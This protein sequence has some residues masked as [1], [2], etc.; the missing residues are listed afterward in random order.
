MKSEFLTVTSHEFGTPITILKG[1]ISMFL[2]GTFG[3]L[4]KLQRKRIESLK[5]SIDRLAKMRR[6]TILLSKLDS[7]KLRLKKEKIAINE[8]IENIANEISI[9]AKKNNQ[10]IKTN[11]KECKIYCDKDTM[12]EVFENLLSNAVKYSGEGSKIEVNL[13]EG[14]ENVLITVSDNGNGIPK[15]KLEKIFERFYI[16]HDYLHHKEGTGL[17]LAIVKEIVEAHCGKVW[18][19]SKLNKGARFNIILP[20]KK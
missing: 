17:G 14:K 19:E 13:K 12:Q 4:T 18:C 5:S 20:K 1:N 8:L 11:L 9:L 10:K 15:D 6:Q 7:G 2:D 16:A 3:K